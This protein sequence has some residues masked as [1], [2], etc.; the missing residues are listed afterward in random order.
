MSST[1]DDFFS[2]GI[3]LDSSGQPLDDHNNTSTIIKAATT[4]SLILIGLALIFTILKVTTWMRAQS[5]YSRLRAVKARILHLEHLDLSN[6]HQRHI[7]TQTNLSN[8]LPESLASQAHR[9]QATDQGKKKLRNL[10]DIQEYEG[11]PVSTTN[12]LPSLF[13]FLSF[14]YVQLSRV[15]VIT[16]SYTLLKS[17][18]GLEYYVNLDCQLFQSIT[19]TPALIHIRINLAEKYVFSRL[20]YT[21]QATLHAF[22][23]NVHHVTSATF[24][25]HFYFD[26]IISKPTSERQLFVL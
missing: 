19:V 10:F 23:R 2:S 25:L 12:N 5:E 18:T 11:T 8:T 3:P 13:S 16:Q 7:L 26:I 6:H 21:H 14:T 22:R 1:S 17:V 24:E 20:Q 9:I 15:G 4:V